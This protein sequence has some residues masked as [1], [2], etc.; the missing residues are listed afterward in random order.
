MFQ[1]LVG[2]VLAG[3]LAAA[4][5]KEE[6]VEVP[7]GQR[8]LFLDDHGIAELSGLARTMH[9]PEKRGAVIKP[10]IPSDGNRVQT[11][12]SVPMW[13]P[14]ENQ[15]K[16]VYMAFP[17]G[18]T[19][20][21]G[22]ALAVSKD[23]IHWEKPDL[24]QG[25]EV[26]GST[27]NNRFFVERGLRWGDNALWN[28]IY[29]A[30]D[31]NPEQRYKGMLGAVG[32]VPVASK[33]CI[34]WKRLA[35]A[36]VASGD[37]STLTYDEERHRFLAL[38]KTFNQYGRA[39]ALSVSEDFV[40]WSE[41]RLCFSTDDTDQKMAHD[42]I[43]RRV[44][45]QHFEVP[46]YVDP[47]PKPDFKP[48]AGHI[49]TW[50][51]ECYCFAAFPYEGV[52]IGLP[53]IYYPTGQELPTRDNTDGFDS[54]QLVM[55]R[56]L[57][58]WER[59]G[60]RREFIGPSPTDNGLIGVFD[61]MQMLP[62]SKPLVM[63]EELWFYYTGF[64]TRMPPYSRNLD[65]SPRKP[66]TLTAKERADL[67]DGWSA[68]CLAV[69]RRDGF[70]SLDAG[71][72]PGSLLTKPFVVRGTKLFVNVDANGGACD[73]EVLGSDGKPLAVSQSVTGDQSRA[74]ISWKSGSL[75]S[76]QGQ[77]VQ[78]RFTLRNARLYSFW[79]DK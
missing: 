36:K 31:P 27:K 67:A 34:H 7:V 16:M 70:I 73:V 22:A 5:V 61:R 33:D 47:E 43:G 24:G 60:E 38:L 3:L 50:R 4:D 76:V 6:S 21:I 8:Q 19:D 68:I 56:D 9:S 1:L 58:Q 48:P 44:T 2:P 53:M 14:E 17:V 45:N 77:T 37:T 10:D 69:L 66:A 63:G 40:H 42:I 78:L 64:K 75:A 72:T 41:P 35:D 39:A 18:N 71:E 28:V 25:V 52:Y 30:K 49:P 54:L 79:L 32:R 65:G 20:Q 51:A 15:Y 57:S 11:Y 26:Q 13:V 12:G 55:S 46:L 59:L 62:P 29:D 74:E 23:G